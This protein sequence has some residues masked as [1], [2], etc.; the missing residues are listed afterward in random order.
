MLTDK[1]L[2]YSSGLIPGMHRKSIFLDFCLASL[3]SLVGVGAALYEYSPELTKNWVVER[4]Q[5]RYAEPP[6]ELSAEEIESKT[7]NVETNLAPARTVAFVETKTHLQRPEANDDDVWIDADPVWKQ[8]DPW[9]DQLFDRKLDQENGDE[10]EFDS[11]HL[12]DQFWNAA[13]P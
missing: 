1:I 4:F 11:P 9:A 13:T 5:Q 10:T 6:V 3:F 2:S 12:H 7:T 8:V